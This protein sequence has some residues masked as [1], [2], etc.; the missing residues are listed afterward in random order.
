MNVVLLEGD[1]EGDGS[2]AVERGG[3][4]HRQRHP[5]AVGKEALAAPLGRPVNELEDPLESQARHADVVAVRVGQ[6]HR[7]AAV[8]R[9]WQH[10]SLGR[11]DLSPV[12][13]GARIWGFA[14]HDFTWGIFLSKT[15]G[16]GALRLEG[17]WS[18]EA[19]KAEGPFLDRFMRRVR[20]QVIAGRSWARGS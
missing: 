4:F 1:G 15:I 16:E 13:T 2:K 18:G 17:A 8:V 6:R 7:E 19:A 3:C 12:P 20:R 14:L 9:D 11:S 10:R 5:G